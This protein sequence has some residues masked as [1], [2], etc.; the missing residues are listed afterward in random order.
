MLI[1]NRGFSE[2]ELVAE[3]PKSDDGAR[4][5][6][7]RVARRPRERGA[8]DVEARRV[9]ERFDDAADAT[10]VA[11]ERRARRGDA[12]AAPAERDAAAERRRVLLARPHEV[13]DELPLREGRSAAGAALEACVLPDRTSPSR[14][15]PRSNRRR[16]S[17][18]KEAP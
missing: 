12:R 9:D 3:K 4:V 8:P 16:S 15:G 14:Q 5:E 11:A 6:P 7:R 1:A 17:R 13:P 18:W 2:S 10:R